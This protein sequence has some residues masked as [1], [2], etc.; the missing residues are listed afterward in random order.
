VLTAGIW[1]M[2][3]SVLTAFSVLGR[4]PHALDATLRRMAA[5]LAG[6][7]LCLAIGRILDRTPLRP[8]GRRWLLA[9]A[10]ALAASLVWALL[11]YA[12]VHVLP[13]ERAADA[14]RNGALREVSLNA[15]ALACV[16]GAWACGW[17]AIGYSDTLA[18]RERALARAQ[19]TAEDARRG[20]SEL[21]ARR[22]RAAPSGQA[23][24]GRTDIWV[25]TR[26]GESRLRLETVELFEAEHDYVRVHAPSGEHL[27]HSGLQ[28]LCDE[29]EPNRF[30]RVHRSFVVNLAAVAQVERRRRGLIELVLASGARV[31][32]GRTYAKVVR[33]RLQAAGLRP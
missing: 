6:V 19:S 29:L 28:A 1:L 15:A 16:F 11:A 30:V 13:A 25:P 9:L 17:L 8:A 33:T 21:E 5:T 32:V 3:F 14:H 18:D 31:P 10:L 24:D 7:A 27:V 23:Q 2:Q 4:Y 12:V 22:D 20:L 26:R